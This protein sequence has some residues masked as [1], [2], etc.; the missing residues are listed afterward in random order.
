[1]ERVLKNNTFIEEFIGYADLKS[2]GPEFAQ[3]GLAGLIY[4]KDGHPWFILIDNE[5]GNLVLIYSKDI[6]AQ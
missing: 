4:E 2:N 1:M 5:T 6:K 3:Q